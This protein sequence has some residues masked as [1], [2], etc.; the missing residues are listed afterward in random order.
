MNNETPP[1]GIEPLTYRLTACHSNQLSYK[2]QSAI[3]LSTRSQ[4]GLNL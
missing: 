4:E 3:A 1:R 2:G